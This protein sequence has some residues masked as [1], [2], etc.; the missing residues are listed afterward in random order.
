MTG[1]EKVIPND[2]GGD[3]EIIRG[4]EAIA[5]AIGEKPRRVYTLL[6]KGALPAW[7]EIGV[8]VTT[9]SRLRDHYENRNHNT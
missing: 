4:A 3:F 1:G 6:E 9:R 7:R 8:W 2:E 5:R